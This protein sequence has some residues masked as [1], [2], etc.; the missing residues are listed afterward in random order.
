MCRRH[1]ERAFTLLE[2]L[3]TIGIMGILASIV[4]I[5]VNP[6]KQIEDTYDAER[7]A[8]MHA[9]LNAVYQYQIE[10]G[11]LPLDYFDAVAIPLNKSQRRDICALSV[12]FDCRIASKAFLYVLVEDEYLTQ[13]PEDPVDIDSDGTGYEI[14]RTDDDRLHV[15]APNF[16]KGGCE[17]LIVSK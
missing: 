16:S 15:C 4:I 14:W 8:E 13:L 2:L 5:A 10:E 1:Q 3:I 6:R 17:G 7:R 9:I 11:H 12:P